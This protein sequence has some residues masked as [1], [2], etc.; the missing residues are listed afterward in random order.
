MNVKIVDRI[1]VKSNERMQV[2]LDWY[3][4]N[5]NWLDKEDFHAPLESR[6]IVLQ[7]EML[8]VAFEEK[9]G[10][11]EIAI[12]PR[13]DNRD[14]PAA[15]IFDYDPQTFELTN[16]RFAPLLHEI[17]RD[18]LRMV[19]LSDR[20]DEKAAMKYHALMLFM[21]HYR[22]IVLVEETKL[23]PQAQNRSKKKKR[24]GKSNAVPLIKRTYV[25][26]DGFN[27]EQLRQ[28]SGEKRHYTKPDHEVNVRGY[29]RHYKSGKVVW[30]KPSVR[31]KDRDKKQSKDYQL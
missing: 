20:T 24:H 26:P 14:C 25:F 8:N 17:K 11:V 4:A 7:E 10:L 21:A 19:I 6:I 12:F 9:R 15:V 31:Y 16:Y 13:M 1:I 23:L 30:V 28:L 29:Q 22:D 18:L 2:V 27:G 3:I 5:R